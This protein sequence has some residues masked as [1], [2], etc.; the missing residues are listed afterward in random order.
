MASAEVIQQSELSVVEKHPMRPGMKRR[1]PDELYEKD[2]SIGV[3]VLMKTFS[4]VTL[5]SMFT[6]YMPSGLASLFG[7]LL[8]GCGMSMMYLVGSEC[9]LGT[10]FDS[11]TANLIG[12]E[13]TKLPLLEGWIAQ[14]TFLAVVSAICYTLGP[15]QFL[16]G[17]IKLWLFPALIM[18]LNLRHLSKKNTTALLALFPSLPQE[19]EDLLKSVPFYKVDRAFEVLS[20]SPSMLE[21]A[22][23]SDLS[24]ERIFYSLWEAICSL[25]PSH[26]MMCEFLYWNKRDILLE[27]VLGLALAIAPLHY[28]DV[29]PLEAFY[30]PFCL[31]FLGF[32]RK[33]HATSLVT[34]DGW[35]ASLYR[36]FSST[37]ADIRA[38]SSQLHMF[39]ITYLGFVHLWAFIGLFTAVPYASWKSLV[40]CVFLHTIYGLGITAGA[41]R[42]W[43]HKSYTATLP[44]KILLMLFNCGAN[45]GSIWHW[46]RDHRAHHRH[47]DTEKDPHNSGYGFFFSHCGWLFLKKDQQVVDAGRA[48]NMQDLNKDGVVMF[49][50][51]YYFPLAMLFCFGLPTLIPIVCWGEDWLVSLTLSYVKYA[52]ILNATWCVNSLAHYSGMRPYRPD[53]PT[54]ENWLVSVMAIG[55]GWHNYHH[56]YPWDYATSEFGAM[57]QFNP[58]KIFIDGCAALGL[59]YDRKR[60]DHL[61]RIARARVAEQQAKK[62]Q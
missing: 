33:A 12:R 4:L 54:A 35:L 62:S 34:P 53:S 14:L 10:Y 38:I 17:F 29:L 56:A 18:Q 23:N 42:L 16:S 21:N 55:E 37:I 2:A 61:G 51:K 20:S 26:Y 1:L 28:Y 57:Y 25:I 9:K 15:E 39:N 3:R 43:S 27:I 22:S 32:T 30:L 45:Q 36:S 24:P 49:Q 47:S 44:V 11:K 46:S 13:L 19:A 59:V 31:L 50:K 5:G 60:A 48:T 52:V 7:M 40:W 6:M 58:T 41:H 8:S